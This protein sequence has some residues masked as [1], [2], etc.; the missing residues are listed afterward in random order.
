MRLKPLENWLPRLVSASN[1]LTVPLVKGL[2]D[3]YI[4]VIISFSRRGGRQE[5]PSR[6]GRL[7][8]GALA[9]DGKRRR[10][11][12]VSGSELPS[13]EGPHEGG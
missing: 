12:A 13:E 8:K 7:A 1:T 4:G 5:R 9:R 6:T 11:G 10:S 2:S 3:S